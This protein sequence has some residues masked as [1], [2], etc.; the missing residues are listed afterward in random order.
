[1]VGDQQECEQEPQGL[2]ENLWEICCADMKPY[3]ICE[4]P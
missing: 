3:E 2:Y 4:K 1:M